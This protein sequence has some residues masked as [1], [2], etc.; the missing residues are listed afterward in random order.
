MF[1]LDD[2]GIWEFCSR[3]AGAASKHLGEYAINKLQ[4]SGKDEM[5]RP[6]FAGPKQLDCR[7]LLY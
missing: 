6:A 2:G 3:S 7:V 1:L 4:L 5:V